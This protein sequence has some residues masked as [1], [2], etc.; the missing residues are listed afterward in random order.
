[1]RV[2][3]GSLEMKSVRG[4]T[5]ARVAGGMFPKVEEVMTDMILM[6]L[7]HSSQHFVQELCRHAQLQGGLISA[8][9]SVF[10]NSHGETDVEI[11]L[12]VPSGRHALLIENKIDAPLMVKQFERYHRRG[13]LGM[14][15]GSWAAYT[16]VLFSPRSYFDHL[17]S[18]HKSFVDLFV[19]YEEIIDF[20]KPMPEFDFK[21]I[22][23]EGASETRSR[24][25]VKSADSTVMEFYQSYYEIAQARFP[26]LKMERPGIRGA[27]NTWAL[28]KNVN[29]YRRVDLVHK[30]L[31]IGCELSIPTDDVDAVRR[32]I[33]PYLETGMTFKPTKSVAYIN[34][35][36]TPVDHFADFETLRPSL[37]EAL[38][39]L[40]RLRRF[41]AKRE[42]DD[43][44]REFAR[45]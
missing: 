7:V 45:P 29:G 6:D 20:L 8:R 38:E 40:D 22:V 34:I 10:D 16:V 9:R 35:Q 11:V 24:G 33:L 14:E 28:F 37:D 13:K 27:N 23:L 19:S 4:R 17:P 21:R 36:S 1:M 12:D 31:A 41:A 25:Y 2:A 26:Q 39:T 44:I 42:V 15:Q 43:I 32:A 5:V 30:W 18:E 3:D